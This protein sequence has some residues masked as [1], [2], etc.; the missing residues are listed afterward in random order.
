MSGL[1][2]FNY[3]AFYDAESQL[4]AFGYDTLNPARNPE[5]D[6]WE[7]Y[8]REAIAQ[9]VQADGIAFLPGSKDSRGARL[10]LNLAEVLRMDVRPLHEWLS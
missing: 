1:P 2:D 9:V 6:S 5:Q 4:C 7:G 10:E 8:M 3:P